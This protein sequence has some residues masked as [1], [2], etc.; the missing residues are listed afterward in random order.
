MDIIAEREKGNAALR[1]VDIYRTCDAFHGAS[2]EHKKTHPACQQSLQPLLSKE[3]IRGLGVEEVFSCTTCGYTSERY[4]LY[5]EVKNSG[6][7][8]RAV[9]HNTSLQI[10]LY[11]TTI[12]TTGIRFFHAW[13]LRYHQKADSKRGLI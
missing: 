7:G 13:T 1:F 3:V 12:G 6:R 4:K 11:S 2:Q 8:R 5:N 10:G 9:Q